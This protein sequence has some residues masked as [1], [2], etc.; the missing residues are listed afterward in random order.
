VI[1]VVAQVPQDSLRHV[2]RDVFAAREYQWSHTGPGL[3]DR[4]LDGSRWLLARLGA[5]RHSHPAAYYALLGAMMLVLLAILAHFAYLAW[6]VLRF[7]AAEGDAA[8][9]GT[10]TVIQG[11]GWH[12]AAARQLAA[13][14]RYGQA[15]G[16]RFLALVLE[17]E[18]RR[19]LSFRPSKTP[20]EYVAEAQLPDVARSALADLV[21]ALYGHLFGGAPCGPEEW[22]RFDQLA[23]E[24]GSHA[25]R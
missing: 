11:P 8:T 2:L 18:S 5:L 9:R 1:P 13:Q 25:A 22:T 17:L 20:A 3:L 4:L 16:H 10:A 23:A 24:L 19:A 12:L 15:L 14:G 7:R 21:G 6:R